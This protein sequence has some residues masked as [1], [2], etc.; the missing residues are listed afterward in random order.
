MTRIALF[1]SRT[2]IDPAANAEALVDGDRRGGGGRRGDAVHAGDV[3]P[4]RPRFGARGGASSRSEDDDRGARRGAARRRGEHGIWVHLGSLAVRADGGKLANRGFVIDGRARSAPAT[5]RSICSTS[6]CRPARAG[7][8]RRSIAAGDG[9]VVVDGTPVGQLGL[10]I[11]YDLRFPALFARLTEAGA[12]V[13]AVPAAFT[14]PTGEAHWHVLLRA[15]AIEAGPVRRRRRAGRPARGR[16]RDL[17]PF[18][19]RRPV[20][21]GAAR[22]GRRASAS[23]SPRSTSRGSPRCAQRLPALHHR[24]PIG[25]ARG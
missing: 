3:G 23:A 21:R 11:C 24:R 18:A 1:Q 14:V 15:R 8:N 7:A 12:D 4:A 5:T 17:R 6:I 22:H 20:G 13:I 10:S 2:G 25:P 19:G 9:A 16:P